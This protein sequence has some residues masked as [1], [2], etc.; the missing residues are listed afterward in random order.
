MIHSSGISGGSIRR[1]Q[2]IRMLPAC[3]RIPN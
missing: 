3:T 2:P 1:P